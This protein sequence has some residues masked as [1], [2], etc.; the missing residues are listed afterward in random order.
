MWDL[1]VTLQGDIN[2]LYRKLGNL[3]DVGKVLYRPMV[4]S[5]AL[6]QG[7]LKPYPAKAA[8]A[9]SRLA[10]PK[11]RRAYWARVKKGEISHGPSGYVRTNTL[12]RRWYSK[13]TR[14]A[15]GVRGE[16]GNNADYGPYVQGA[17]NQQSFHKASGWLTTSKVIN[18]NARSIVQL[19]RHA[20]DAELSK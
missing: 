8:G 10:T 18:D 9:F 16:V 5:T 2:A 6:M 19:F 11:Q 13:V 7:K 20:I 14:S 12:G 4:Q 1:S 17:L 15:N 3:E